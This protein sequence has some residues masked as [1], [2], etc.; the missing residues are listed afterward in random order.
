MTHYFPDKIM[1]LEEQTQKN[2]IF[3]IIFSVLALY[4]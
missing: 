2:G 3:T 1:I 4:R